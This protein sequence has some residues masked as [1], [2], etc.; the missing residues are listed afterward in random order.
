MYFTPGE[1][2]IIAYFYETKI[3]DK[4]QWERKGS[5]GAKDF[6]DVGTGGGM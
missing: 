5:F 4:S 3:C 6:G 1:L 2:V